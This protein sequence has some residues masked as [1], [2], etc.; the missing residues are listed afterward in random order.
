MQKYD[1]FANTQA[2]VSIVGKPMTRNILKENKL[3]HAIS[4]LGLRV[5]VPTCQVHV[6][7]LHADNA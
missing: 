2:Q 7:E 5:S 4:D 6:E 3:R 1:W